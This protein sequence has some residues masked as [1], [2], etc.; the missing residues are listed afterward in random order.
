MAWKEYNSL[1]H[2]DRTNEYCYYNELSQP[3]VEA[4]E[5]DTRGYVYDEDLM[6]A[7]EIEEANLLL[8]HNGAISAG[9]AN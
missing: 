6:N 4:E 8:S 2:S 1:V 5:L 7:A 3:D 9:S